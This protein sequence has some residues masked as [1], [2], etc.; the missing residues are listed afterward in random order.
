M[1]QESA[2]ATLRRIEQLLDAR[3]GDDNAEDLTVYE[4]VV[5]VVAGFD[6]W[7]DLALRRLH[8][9]HRLQGQECDFCSKY[10][11]EDRA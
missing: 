6:A 1:E 5:D 9:I 11:D 8:E 3:M 7:V 10:L 2:E 4:R